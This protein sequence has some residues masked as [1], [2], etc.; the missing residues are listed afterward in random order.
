VEH[1]AHFLILLPSLLTRI[2]FVA[3][4]V[5]PAMGSACVY[6]QVKPSLRV[7]MPGAHGIAFHTDREYHHQA[8]EVNVWV[9]LTDTFGSNTLQLESQPGL[10][11][12]APLQLSYG[13]CARFWGNQCR[14][15]TLTNTETWSRVSFDLRVIREEVSASLHLP[16]VH[17][18]RVTAPCWRPAESTLRYRLQDF[19]PD[20]LVGRTKE[21]SQRYVAGA[22]YR[23]TQAAAVEPPHAAVDRQ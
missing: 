7:Q 8:G 23:R 13:E 19:S 21:G 3:N 5:A 1:G 6:Y 16:R 2:S 15:G 18:S 4:V 9:P 14:H 12:F 20:P 10:G 11:D 17:S 22:Y